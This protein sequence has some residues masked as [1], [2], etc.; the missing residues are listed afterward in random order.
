MAAIDAAR[1]MS[2]VCFGYKLVLSAFLFALI[3]WIVVLAAALVCHATLL[4][5]TLCFILDAFLAALSAGLAFSSVKVARARTELLAT[6][7]RCAFAEAWMKAG[8]VRMQADCPRECWL[9]EVKVDC[10]CG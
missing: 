7:R 4:F 1:D 10:G 3:L 2:V 8:Y 6:Q 5:P 9:P